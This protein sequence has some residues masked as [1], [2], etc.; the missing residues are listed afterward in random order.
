VLYTHEKGVNNEN[1]PITAF[2]QSGYLDIADGNSVSFVRKFVPDFK[3]QQGNLNIQLLTRVY[4]NAQAK[5]SVTDLHDIS[6]TTEKVDTRARGR[7]V[8]LKIQSQSVDTT[9]RI[10]DNRILIQPDGLR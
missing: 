8:S 2:I 4:P 7:Q 6:P 3:N 10:G 9:W 1:Q 5:V